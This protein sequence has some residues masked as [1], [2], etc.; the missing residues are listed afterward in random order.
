MDTIKCITTRRSVRKFTDAP[1]DRTLIDEILEAARWAPS[2]LNNQPWR[3]IIIMDSA[4]RQQL[5]GLTKYGHIIANAP[6]SIA[7]FID[8]DAM[9][10]ETKDHQ[11][12]GACIQNMLLAAHALQLGAVW[13]G[14]I[15]NKAREVHEALGAPAS[16][17]LMAVVALGHPSSTAH[18]SE[19]KPLNELILKEI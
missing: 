6:V 11:G 14:E 12:M 19:R 17:E 4:I 10:N 9:Y 7:I 3:F 1:V 18:Q 8:R 16:M 2:G 13:L 5:A 15:L